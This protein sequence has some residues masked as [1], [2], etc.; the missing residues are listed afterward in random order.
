MTRLSHVRN[1]RLKETCRISFHGKLR[2]LA[3]PKRN[4]S[5]LIKIEFVNSILI[6]SE[7]FLFSLAEILF[8]FHLHT[9]DDFCEGAQY[10]PLHLVHHD[11]ERKSFRL[12]TNLNI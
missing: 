10:N 9:I 2:M 6:N 12:H 11:F 3:K 1:R 4:F 8:T 7:K 5:E